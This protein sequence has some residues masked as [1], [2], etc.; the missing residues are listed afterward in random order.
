MLALR[1]QGL[2][3]QNQP[4][5]FRTYSYLN[6]QFKQITSI[7]I[8]KPSEVAPKSTPKAC[9]CHQLQRLQILRHRQFLLEIYSVFLTEELL[10]NPKFHLSYQI[11][12]IYSQPISI[13]KITHTSHQN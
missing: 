9:M 3:Q 13:S 6:Y 11:G 2:E 10:A 7:E 4:H 1:L 8:S 12:L 5:K